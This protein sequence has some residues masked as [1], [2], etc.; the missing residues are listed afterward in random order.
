M[1]EAGTSVEWEPPTKNMAPRLALGGREANR[2]LLSLLRNPVEE[3]TLRGKDTG[4]QDKEFNLLLI[5]S[6]LK[7][8]QGSFRHVV[9][10]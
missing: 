2:M 4:R 10:L 3:F 5:S 9:H 7:V 1:R 6:S 8:S